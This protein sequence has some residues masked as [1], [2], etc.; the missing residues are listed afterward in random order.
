MQKLIFFF[1]LSLLSISLLVSCTGKAQKALMIEGCWLDETGVQA[2]EV[3]RLDAT[4]ARIQ[5]TQGKV[6]GTVSG[7]TLSAPTPPPL[8]ETI[9]MIF[10]NDT[11][12]YQ[13]LG[14]EQRFYRVSKEQ[15]AT[16]CPELPD[17]PTAEEE[18][19]ALDTVQTETAPE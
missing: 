10:N 2:L 15:A 3:V 13:F 4:Q 6:D 14:T 9:R 16:L 18:A 8:Q 7:D 12:I 17:L 1:S 19:A 11:A 5:S